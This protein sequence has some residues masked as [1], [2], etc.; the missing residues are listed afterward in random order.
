MK[1]LLF[2]LIIAL[3]EFCS[4]GI[5][6]NPEH[7]GLIQIPP[8]PFYGITTV[9][10]TLS[11]PQHSVLTEHPMYTLLDRAEGDKWIFGGKNLNILCTTV[12]YA[13]I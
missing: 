4:T 9:V 3:T 11:S 5:P 1:A 2:F 7:E 8:D 12:I 13:F 6:S 10:S